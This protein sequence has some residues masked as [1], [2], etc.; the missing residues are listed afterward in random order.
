MLLKNT[1]IMG[2]LLLSQTKLMTLLMQQNQILIIGL[3]DLIVYLE[4]SGKQ[5]I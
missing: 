5:G 4:K 1:E 3:I 2:G